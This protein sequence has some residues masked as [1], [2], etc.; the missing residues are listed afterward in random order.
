MPLHS[1]LSKKMGPDPSPNIALE[2]ATA[3]VRAMESKLSTEEYNRNH[4]NTIVT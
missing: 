3:P 2:N 1:T 4:P